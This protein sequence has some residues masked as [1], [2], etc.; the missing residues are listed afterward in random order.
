MNLGRKKSLLSF[1][2]ALI[3]AST[4]CLIPIIQ[5]PADTIMQVDGLITDGDKPTGLGFT[6][7]N[8]LS[9]SGQSEDECRIIVNG[10]WYDK[11]RTSVWW[12]LLPMVP[13]FPSEPFRQLIFDF[14][15][16]H[17]PTD[18]EY[19]PAKIDLIVKNLSK[20]DYDKRHFTGNAPISVRWKKS[21]FHI[22]LDHVKL[23]SIDDKNREIT[24]RGN[25][26][27]TAIDSA[28]YRIEPK[29]NENSTAR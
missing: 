10:Y 29:N 6:A 20:T 4:G 24:I 1:L 3:S 5:P 15:P 28:T 22:R 21:N 26:D 11:P 23:S 13:H 8:I 2:V 19:R 18:D 14:T 27:G 16:L 9:T 17:I 12:Y 7:P 25:I